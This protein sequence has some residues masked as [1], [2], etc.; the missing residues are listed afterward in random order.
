M[1][2]LSCSPS[3]P[4]LWTSLSAPS[5]QADFCWKLSLVLSWQR[6]YIWSQ[7][8]CLASYPLSY[9]YS[10]FFLILLS[11]SVHPSRVTQ[12][13]CRFWSNSVWTRTQISLTPVC[14]SFWTS[15]AKGFVERFVRSWK[16]RKEPRTYA[17]QQLTRGMLSRSELCLYPP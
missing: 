16:S 8:H 5:C 10:L 13:G 14:S 9:T 17:G 6:L 7:P 12:V 1:T 4:L 11:L 3:L 2:A 15:S